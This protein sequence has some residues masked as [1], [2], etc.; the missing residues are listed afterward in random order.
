MTLVKGPGSCSLSISDN[1]AGFP[2]AIIEKL[3]NSE[4][5]TKAT[6]RREG[7]FFAKLALFI[8]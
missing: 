6:C 3:N 4:Y 5:F 7:A 8:A 2:Q 1:G